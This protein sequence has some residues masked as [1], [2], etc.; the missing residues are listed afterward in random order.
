MSQPIDFSAEYSRM[1]EQELMA[2]ARNYDDLTEA[3]RQAIRT[4]FAKRR[5]E[6]PILDD[7]EPQPEWSELATVETFRD[8]TEAMVAQSVLRSAGIAAY[9]FDDNFVRIYWYLSN[10]IGGIRLRVKAEDEGAAKEILNEP[11]PASIPFN[12]NE[13]YSQPRCPGC[14]SIDISFN[15]ASR[16]AALAGLYAAGL[17]LPTGDKSWSCSNCGARWQQSED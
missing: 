16:G 15:G 3:A 2:V 8:L 14:G 4:E 10:F 5:L 13:A 1:N 7:P 6:P 9:L 12:E 11:A 17:P